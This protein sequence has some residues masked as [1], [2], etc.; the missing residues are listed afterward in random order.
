[1]TNDNL[2]VRK[3]NGRMCVEDTASKGIW[4]PYHL[5]SKE[6]DCAKDPAARA[7]ELCIRN[8][9]QDGNWWKPK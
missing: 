2:I 6:I 9:S 4:I 5:A 1:M 3:I 8:R 7:I